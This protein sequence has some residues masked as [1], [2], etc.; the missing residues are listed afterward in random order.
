MLRFRWCFQSEGFKMCIYFSKLKTAWT[1]STVC[2][3]LICNTDI[4]DILINKGGF[5]I[6]Y[7]SNTLATGR[8]KASFILAVINGFLS[9]FLPPPPQK[10]YNCLG[11]HYCDVW[12]GEPLLWGL[13]IVRELTHNQSF[14]RWLCHCLVTSLL[15]FSAS[16]N[17]TAGDHHTSILHLKLWQAITNRSVQSFTRSF[18]AWLNYVSRQYYERGWMDR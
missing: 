2:V 6:M 4:F 12:A 3:R 8:T 18:H 9:Y 11:K 16:D 17:P 15:N 10:K 14:K 5:K 13:C 1:R 7:F